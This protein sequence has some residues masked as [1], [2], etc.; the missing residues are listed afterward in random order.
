MKKKTYTNNL[1]KSNEPI[2]NEIINSFKKRDS[3]PINKTNSNK[4]NNRFNVNRKRKYT[5]KNTNNSNINYKYNENNS[6]FEKERRFSTNATHQPIL[7]LDTIST[8]FSKIKE[9]RNKILNKFKK[10]KI[11]SKE[12]ALYIL[13]TSPILR[14]CEQ[15]IFA[16]STNNIKNVIKLDNIL[17]NHII[18]LNAKANELQNEIYLCKKRINT[19]FVASKIADITLNFITSIDEQEF[20]NYDILEMNKDEINNYYNYIRLLYILFNENYDNKTSGKNLKVKL[21]DKL[22]IKGFS[23]IRD[24]LYHI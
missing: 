11:S 20:K 10:E 18:F 16:N 3:M 4:S 24:Y 22:K 6:V 17:N 7:S 9:R 13:S 23:Y 1:K 12:Q 15:L 5:L 14:L 8:S 21:F 19:P 2:K